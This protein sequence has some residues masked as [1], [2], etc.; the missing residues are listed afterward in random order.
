[1]PPRFDI[2][3]AA[4]FQSRDG[5]L[6]TGGLI[7]NG[8]LEKAPGGVWSWQRPA[9]A[10]GNGAPF[11]GTALGML[12]LGGTLYGVGVGTVG[13]ASSWTIQITT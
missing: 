11:I 4:K 9:L 12:V 5:G 7:R 3:P 8:F 2:G 13:T 10:P 1:M 6:G